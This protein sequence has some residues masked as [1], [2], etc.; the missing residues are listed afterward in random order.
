MMEQQKKVK[1]IHETLGF[2]HN[3][4]EALI[5]KAREVHTVDEIP[6]EPLKANAKIDSNPFVINQIP[7]RIH[8]DRDGPR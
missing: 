8:L 5:E 7:N 1:I 4:A 6:L 2:S 3:D